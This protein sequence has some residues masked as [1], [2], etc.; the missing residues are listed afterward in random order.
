VYEQLKQIL[1]STFQADPD[2][3]APDATLPDLGLDSLDLV[4]LS[5]LIKSDLAVEVSDDELADLAAVG[6]VAG[7]LESRVARV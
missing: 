4:E 5:I 1:V 3:V 6:D 2:A 7:L